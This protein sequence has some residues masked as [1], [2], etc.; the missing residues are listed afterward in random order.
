MGSHSARVAKVASDLGSA[1]F[2][3]DTLRVEG[4]LLCQKHFDR[5]SDE[6]ERCSLILPGRLERDRQNSCA[7]Q[8]VRLAR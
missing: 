4:V 3:D 6:N 2:G 1:I 7:V 5:A 8:T